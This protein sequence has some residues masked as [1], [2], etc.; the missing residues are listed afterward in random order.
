MGW[1]EEVLTFSLVKNA[2]STISKA[3]MIKN[4]SLNERTMIRVA[5]KTA[6]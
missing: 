5:F 3:A 6:L 4:F 1:T 2:K